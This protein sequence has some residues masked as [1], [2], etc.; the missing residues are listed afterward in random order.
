MSQRSFPPQAFHG[1]IDPEKDIYAIPS[2]LLS[3]SGS[4]GTKEIY[5]L[6][7]V[8]YIIFG[9]DKFVYRNTQQHVLK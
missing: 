7:L 6:A 1:K 9:K 2:R 3:E 5:F 4:G 8:S